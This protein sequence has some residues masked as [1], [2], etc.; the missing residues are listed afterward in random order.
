M[1]HFNALMQAGKAPTGHPSHTTHLSKTIQANG[2]LHS[3]W[4][5]DFPLQKRMKSMDEDKENLQKTVGTTLHMSIKHWSYLATVHQD[6]LTFQTPSLH[7]V[8]RSNSMQRCEWPTDPESHYC[9]KL[10]ECLC[11]ILIILV[12]LTNEPCHKLY[13][14]HFPPLNPLTLSQAINTLCGD[15]LP[16]PPGT[17]LFPAFLSAWMCKLCSNGPPGLSP[18]PSPLPPFLW[19]SVAVGREWVKRDSVF[20]LVPV[21][22]SWRELDMPSGEF[23]CSVPQMG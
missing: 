1:V 2:T 6:L 17:S 13:L 22:G 11:L 19:T 15:T 20:L 23:L 7:W 4:A 12:G 9:T 18:R 21:A 16:A 10:L 3:S 5:N 8:R 14:P